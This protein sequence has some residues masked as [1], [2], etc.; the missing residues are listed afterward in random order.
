MFGNGYFPGISTTPQANSTF[1]EP[2]RVT[3][4]NARVKEGLRMT[5]RGSQ[6]VPT[7]TDFARSMLTEINFLR[8]FSPALPQLTK[9]LPRPHP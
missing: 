9:S 6:T 2:R 1:R 3:T 4:A 5:T 8:C 7:E